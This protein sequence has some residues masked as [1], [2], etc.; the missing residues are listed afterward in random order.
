VEWYKTGG[1]L[2]MGYEMYRLMASRKGHIAQP[3]KPGRKA[4]GK[5]MVIDVDEEDKTRDM[6]VR[7]ESNKETLSETD[8]H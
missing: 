5:D 4:V 6:H 1:C 8:K 7:S 3:K 2:L